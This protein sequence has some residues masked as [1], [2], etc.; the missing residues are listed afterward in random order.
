MNDS[1]SQ[2]AA[3]SEPSSTPR[4]A[5]RQ[6]AV[7]A[8]LREVAPEAD[9]SVLQPAERLRDQLDLDS[10]DFLNFLIGLHRRTGAEIPESDYARLGT[11][12]DVLAYLAAHGA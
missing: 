10:M 3:V 4:A 8:A 9:L 1:Q 11:L 7:F 2:G 12:E 6:A 5:A